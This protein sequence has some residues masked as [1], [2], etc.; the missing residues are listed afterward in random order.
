MRQLTWMF[1]NASL[2]DVSNVFKCRCILFEHVMTESDV[3]GEV[4]FVANDLHSSGELLTGLFI[5]AFLQTHKKKTEHGART[6]K[7][8][9]MPK[10]RFALNQFSR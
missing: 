7:K 10:K 9:K 5:L 1:T 6:N 2:N 4:W 3:I 8:V